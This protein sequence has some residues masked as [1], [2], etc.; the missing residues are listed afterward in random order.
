M[1]NARYEMSPE[2][3]KT[4]SSL[5]KIA[6]EAEARRLFASIKKYAKPDEPVTINR[7]RN[8]NPDMDLSAINQYLTLF[9]IYGVIEGAIVQAEYGWKSKATGKVTEQ[10]VIWTP[11]FRIRDSYTAKKFS[12][13]VAAS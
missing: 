1:R 7:L 11:A 4:I 3:Q 8:E 5:E 2:T 10:T 13:M 12:K 9:K 6:K